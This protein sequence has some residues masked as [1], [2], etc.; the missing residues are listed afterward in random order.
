MERKLIA[1]MAA[2]VAGY[3]ALM[4]ANEQATIQ[5]LQIVLSRIVR[6]AVTSHGGKIVKLMGDG[7]LSRFDSA[8]DATQSALEIQTRL[9]EV[10]PELKLRIGLHLGDVMVSGNDILGDGVNIACRLETLAQPGGIIAS[11]QL[12]DQITQHGFD[13]LIPNGPQTIK[14]ITRPI[15]T[16][17]IPTG[18][19][20]ATEKNRLCFDEF[21]LNLADFT[22]LRSGTPVHVEPLVFDFLRFLTENAGHTITRDAAIDEVWKGRIVSDATVASCLK[23]A[24]KALGDDGETQKYIRT[25]RGRG[26][27]FE[28]TLRSA[29]RPGPRPPAARG[30]GRRSLAVMPFRAVQDSSDMAIALSDSLSTVL[31]RI[32]MLAILSPQSAPS[33]SP[34]PQVDFLVEG[35]LRH[36]SGEYQAEIRLSHG[37]TGLQLWGQQFLRPDRDDPKQALLFDILARLEPELVQAMLRDLSGSTRAD[38]ASELLIKAMSL[39]AV[40]GWHRSTFEDSA[41]M[42]RRSISLDPGNPYAHSHLALIL[43]LGHR[44]GSLPKTEDITREALREAEIALDQNSEDSTVVSIS[45]CAIADLGQTRRAVPL[46]KKA[47]ALNANNAH[48][49]AA[50]GSAHMMLKRNGEAIEALEKG[51]RLAPL[52]TRLA[53]WMAVLAL[54]YLLDGNPARALDTAEKACQQDDRNYLPRLA[55]TAIHLRGKDSGAAQDSCHDMLRAK[56]DLTR[57]EVFSF[58]GK[59][60]GSPVLTLCDALGQ[61]RKA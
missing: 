43:A 45:A 51:V 53:V 49:W 6:P 52:D 15:E 42:L 59:N 41:D 31:S 16:F 11:R 23:A 61:P 32:P 40:K 8:L 55:L 33:G 1:I 27:R 44:F 21:E 3:S 22:L 37:K 4:E 48:A 14:N 34:A 54:V 7:M 47:I 5:R 13:G 29:E 35:S 25:I 39:L 12:C 20:G 2:D 60:L 50:L 26:F 10:D 24:R 18:Q 57:N 19:S 9:S 17:S 28:G 56:P 58:L 46:L 36:V 38:T 30:D